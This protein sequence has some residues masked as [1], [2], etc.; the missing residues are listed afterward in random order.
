M[1]LD[2]EEFF[3]QAELL[4]ASGTELGCRWAI[5]RR[6]YGCHLRARDGLFGLDAEFWPA[7]PHRPSHIA[8]I[9]EL[10]RHPVLSAIVQDM[11]EL[12]KMREV[13]DYIRGNEHPE[14]LRLFS[15][16]QV[17]SWQELAAR[18]LPRARATFAALQQS[19]P[20]N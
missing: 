3:P 8:V 7:S 5:N 19:L 12:K 1:A 9:N 6:Y 17:S 15:R 10:R 20:A 18:A 11:E 14:V 13:A 4:E 2:L 16:Y